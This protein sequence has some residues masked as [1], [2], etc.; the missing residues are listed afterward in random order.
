[1]LDLV[2]ELVADILEDA[3]ICDRLYGGGASG[4][5]WDLEFDLE[6]VNPIEKDYGD[7][8]YKDL[9]SLLK[10]GLISKDIYKKLY[11]NQKAID[12][13]NKKINSLKKKKNVTYFELRDILE[14]LQ[15]EIDNLHQLGRMD[16]E[17]HQTV[18]DKIRVGLAE[19]AK[20]EREHPNEYY[21][22]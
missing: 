1:M 3:I 4:N 12:S 19:I 14:E 5:S 6:P 15:F 22:R 16:Y 9:K 11:S 20:F 2:I 7:N 10:K 18:S 8:P 17:K 21:L 13:T